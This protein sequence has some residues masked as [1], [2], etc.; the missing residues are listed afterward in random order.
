MPC[1]K[2]VTNAKNIN[3]K[4]EKESVMKNIKKILAMLLAFTMIFGM[5]L[6]TMAAE[7]TGAITVKGLN[8]NEETTVKIYQI[9]T[10]DENKNEWTVA[11]WANSYVDKTKNPATIN[12]EG[13]KGEVLSEGSTIAEKDVKTAGEGVTEVTFS[14]LE[15]GAYLMIAA[16]SKSTYNV[17]GASLYAYDE[18]THLITVPVE[19]PIVWAKYSDYFVEKTINGADDQFVGRGDEIQFD[20][21]TTFPSYE[22]NTTDRAFEIT[23]TPNG[24][25]ITGVTVQ[26]GD[27]TVDEGIAYQ[28]IFGSANTADAT[29]KL[30]AKENEAVTVSFE[31]TYIGDENAHAGES[32]V[33]T[34]TAIVTSDTTISNTAT[35][36]KTDQSDT[37]DAYTGDVTITKYAF[38]KDNDENVLDNEVL[39]GAEFR[40]YAG[41]K[42]DVNS[43][44][45]PALYFVKVSDGVYKLAESTESE[46]A[47][48]IKVG[49]SGT[50][51]GK[52]QVKGL[53]EGTYWF[54][55]TK[56]PEGY[57]VNADGATVTI[58]AD[59]N[60]NIS[61]S[62]YVVDSKLIALPSTGGLGTTIFTIVG[63]TGMVVAGFYLFVSRRKQDKS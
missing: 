48:T 63:C 5:S 7:E 26:V 52:V 62:G 61:I 51:K 54:E 4:K 13:L 24:L 59:G 25:K 53:D 16:G 60:K 21:T 33:V 22:T 46:A 56:A 23:D 32:V 28:L 39:T 36:D 9:V 14:N 49:A 41:S 3:S 31:S 34:V 18:N 44:N 47:Q 55:E 57:S 42:D 45:L 50:Q 20:I 38:E 58:T 1:L 43:K 30:P 40:V 2:M 11:D 17:M 19:D 10:L 27:V 12:W 37:V 29:T 15:I 8:A 6:T 35:T